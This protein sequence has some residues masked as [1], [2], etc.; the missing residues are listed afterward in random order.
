MDN[1]HENNTT[2]TGKDTGDGCC[3][4]CVGIYLC[5][6]LLITCISLFHLW[7][8]SYGIIISI[9]IIGLLAI[10][11]LSAIFFRP[12][13]KVFSTIADVFGVALGVAFGALGVVLVVSMLYLVVIG[14]ND[15][16]D[17]HNERRN[18]EQSVLKILDD[19]TERTYYYL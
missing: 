14:V 15:W 3:S 13:R 6:G 2:T 8:S 16:I 7:D 9:T 19:G 5:F 11:I 4:G 12:I 1:E 10:T 18:A 17:E